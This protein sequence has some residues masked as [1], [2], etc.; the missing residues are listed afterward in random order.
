MADRAIDRG[1]DDYLL[2]KIENVKEQGRV[3]WVRE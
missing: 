3:N 1:G 2:D